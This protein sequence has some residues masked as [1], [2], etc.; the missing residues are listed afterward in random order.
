MNF[1]HKI[2]RI[3]KNKMG[4]IA[5]LLGMDKVKIVSETSEGRNVTYEQMP[6]GVDSHAYLSERLSEEIRRT[7]SNKVSIIY[8]G[9]AIVAKSH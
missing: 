4:L 9:R 5:K 2:E 8:M 6:E 3:E 1:N 7:K